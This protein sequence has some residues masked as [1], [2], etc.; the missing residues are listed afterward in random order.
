MNDQAIKPPLRRVSREARRPFGSQT[1]KLAYEPRTGYHRH[2]FNDTPG[3]IEQALNAGYQHVDNKEGEKV[4][5]VV[6]VNQAGGAMT[7]YLMEIPDEWYQEDMARGQEQVDQIDQ[8]VRKGAVS[9]KPG[10][11]GVY[12]PESRG[13]KIRDSR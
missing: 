1:Q 7:G 11:D 2:W 8:A 12:V 5:V 3:R 9:G 10:V 13:I 4:K 6:G